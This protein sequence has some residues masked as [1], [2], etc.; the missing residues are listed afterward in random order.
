MWATTDNISVDVKFSRVSSWCI[1]CLQCQECVTAWQPSSNIH[2]RVRSWWCS[3]V[4]TWQLTIWCWKAQLWSHNIV[5]CRHV[6]GWLA[7]TTYLATQHGCL[8]SDGAGAH[9]RK[10]PTTTTHPLCPVAPYYRL[11]YTYH[12]CTMG[13]ESKIPSVLHLISVQ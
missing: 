9:P 3:C 7:V 8:Q 12:L 6:P 1:T 10:L 2:S 13:V 4:T 5:S 11:E